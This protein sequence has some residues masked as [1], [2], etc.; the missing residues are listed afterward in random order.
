MLGGTV[1]KK[2]REGERDRKKKKVMLRQ[3]TL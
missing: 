3:I 2:D 1:K